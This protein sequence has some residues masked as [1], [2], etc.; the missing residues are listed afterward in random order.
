LV[1]ILKD[2]ENTAIITISRVGGF[3]SEN[4]VPPTGVPGN[5]LIP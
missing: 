2:K 3:I 4:G 5:K 1:F